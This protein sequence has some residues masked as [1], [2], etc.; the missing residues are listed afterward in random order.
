MVWQNAARVTAGI[1]GSCTAVVD[2]ILV[3]RLMVGP[4]EQLA[5]A[6]KRMGANKP[7][8]EPASP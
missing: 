2:D 3:Q 7:G 8:F 5:V 1:I 4:F 6:D